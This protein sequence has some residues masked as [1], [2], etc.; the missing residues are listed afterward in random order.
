MREIEEFQKTSTGA[1]IGFGVLATALFV[2]MIFGR[3]L[4]DSMGDWIGEDLE[5][6][7]E[8]VELLILGMAIVNVAILAVGTMTIYQGSKT[9][10]SDR[11]P[12]VGMLVIADT[13]IIRGREARRRGRMLQL[14][15]VLVCIIAIGFPLVF[16][17]IIR[18]LA[19]SL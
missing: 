7:F 18:R 17:L 9:M 5:L 14:G 10:D 11:F 4:Y 6:A 8:R 13:P 1:R 2:A 3:P 19:E 15:G 16:W 12:P